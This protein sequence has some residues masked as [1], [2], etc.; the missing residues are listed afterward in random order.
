MDFAQLHKGVASLVASVVASINLGVVPAPVASPLQTPIVS[1][2]YNISENILNETS[3]PE[4]LTSLNPV[5]E[6]IS[7]LEMVTKE[8]V[9][10]QIPQVTTVEMPEPVFTVEKP[11]IKVEV[12]KTVKTEEP[13][14]IPSVTP[15]PSPSSV[16]EVIPSGNSNSDVMFDMVNEYRSKL[17]LKAFEKDNRLCEIAEKRAPQ[18]NGELQSGTLHKG[19]KD[20]NLPYWA[21]ENI[22]A[23]SSLKEDLN[24]WVSDYIHKKA[25]ESDN[26]YSCVACAGTSC[27]QIFTSF[28]NK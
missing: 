6:D 14:P 26:K 21:T 27:S 3:N 13:S 12:A 24:F 11:D 23:Y 15:S 5:T 4:S 25:I 2:S 8:V 9:E 10:P 7:K 1:D 18:V 19:F 28:V 22:A 20:L 17:G 16:P